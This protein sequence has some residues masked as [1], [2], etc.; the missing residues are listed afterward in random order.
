MT[1]GGGAQDISCKG[2]VGI[3]EKRPVPTLKSSATRAWSP[4]RKPLSSILVSL[5]NTILTRV[6]HTFADAVLMN[7]YREVDREYYLSEIFKP[8]TVAGRTCVSKVRSWAR[9]HQ[10]GDDQISYVFE[11]VLLTKET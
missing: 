5:I 9:E 6:H 8:Y 11:M 7:D 1:D 2:E 4:G 3:R 10:V